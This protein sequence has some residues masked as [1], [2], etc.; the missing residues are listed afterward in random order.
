VLR[1]RGQCPRP[2]VALPYLDA[3]ELL[4][5]DDATTRRAARVS[6]LRKI[7]SH[8]AMRGGGA[9]L[10][11]V[12]LLARATP[13]DAARPLPDEQRLPGW[14]GETHRV[15]V[16]SAKKLRGGGGVARD[17]ASASSDASFFSASNVTTL[18]AS[19]P[20]AYVYRGFLTDAECDHFIA[21][22]SPK[23]AKSNVVDTDTGEG[24][25]S[26]IRTSDGMF[27]DR[28]EDDVVDA[29]ERRISA[30]T[31]LPTE[32]GEGMQVLRYAGG[33]KY[34][35][36]LDAFVDKFNADDAHGGQVLSHT[37]PHTTALAW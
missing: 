22:A 17:D 13:H 3:P 6:N 10:A 37:G 11:A 33:Q 4:H 16:A 35:A 20:R 34:D 5:R 23:L 1:A 19:S 12:L 36:H 9:L 14:L 32:N 25:P 2:A 30:W 28:G 27:F 26:A 24:V 15:D 29:V 7:T 21:R 18:S 8:S 31:R